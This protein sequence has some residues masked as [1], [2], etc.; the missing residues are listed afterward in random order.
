MGW[1]SNFVGYA[2]NI[3]NLG[4]TFV[5]SFML[6]GLTPNLLRALNA[7]VCMISNLGN[8]TWTLIAAAYWTL[9][10]FKMEGLLT[11]YL[12]MGV[13]HLC[14]C[15]NDIDGMLKLLSMAGK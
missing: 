5:V 2:V 12:N 3:A 4:V 13:E 10:T 7:G 9:A 8:N 6:D 11:K 15:K 14:T 1:L